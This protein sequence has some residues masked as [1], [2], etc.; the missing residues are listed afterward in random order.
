MR[1]L[2]ELEE[3]YNSGERTEKLYNEIIAMDES[4]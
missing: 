4:L 1:Q 3:R 2:K